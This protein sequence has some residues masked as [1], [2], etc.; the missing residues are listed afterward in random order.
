MCL[1]LEGITTLFQFSLF[2]FFFNFDNVFATGRNYNVVS[3][4]IPIEIVHFFFNFDSDVLHLAQWNVGVT[5]LLLFP[6]SQRCSPDGSAE[7]IHSCTLPV[8]RSVLRDNIVV[9]VF[10][11]S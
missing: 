7:R 2:I 11:F 6:S 4:L 9:V 1:R 10:P 5:P 8:P 3:I